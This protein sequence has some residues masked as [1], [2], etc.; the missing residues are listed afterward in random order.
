MPPLVLDAAQQEVAMKLGSAE[1]KA[2]FARANVS[3]AIQSQLYHSSICTVSA[4]SNFAKD[5]DDLRQSLKDDFGVDASVSLQMR[6][7]VGAVVSAYQSALS[8]RTEICKL[9][10]ELDARQLQKPLLGSDYLVLRASF[11][12]LYGRQEDC[13][14][15]AKSYLERRIADLESGDFRQELLTSV[16]SRDLDEDDSMVQTWDINGQMRLKRSVNSTSVPANPEELRKRLTVMINGL[17]MISLQHTNREELQGMLPSFRESYCDYL[18]GEY[19]WQFIAK[20]SE[21]NT[22]ATPNWSLVL[23]YELAI[24]KK[25]YAEV[26][27]SGDR[28]H[29][30]I[31][32]AW[33]DPLI[34]ERSFTTPL[35][36]STAAGTRVT[37]TIPVLKTVLKSNSDGGGKGKGAGRGRGRNQGRAQGRGKG[38]GKGGGLS[39]PAGCSAKTPDGRPV[40][41]GFNDP[42]VR[43]KKSNCFEHVCGRCFA[44]HPLYQCPGQRQAAPLGETQGQGPT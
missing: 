20:D 22:V 24:R 35:A 3:A 38:K 26:Q 37:S 5:E 31:R 19:V 16:V 23:Q 32:R 21:G 33:L 27:Q 10:G 4:F 40:C 12:A 25:A 43:C 29:V 34:K 8:R 11:E 1:I 18:F 14:L 13:N 42:A 9:N 17:V 30:C 15:P 2:L 6:V 28:L 7:Q 39:V 36:I 44:K 41:F